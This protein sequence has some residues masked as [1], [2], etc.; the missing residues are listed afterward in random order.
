MLKNSLVHGLSVLVWVA[1]SHGRL[2]RMGG[3]LARDR[4]QA[5]EGCHG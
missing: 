3:A 2:A 5:E 4:A 1:R